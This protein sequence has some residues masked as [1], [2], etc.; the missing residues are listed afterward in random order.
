MIAAGQRFGRLVVLSVR[1]GKH[2]VARCRCD[3]GTDKDVRA[4]VLIAGQAKSC[5]CFRSERITRMSTKHGRC[6]TPEW[7]VWRGLRQRCQDPNCAGYPDYGG[8]GITVCARWDG[9]GGFERFLADMGPRPSPDHSID[10]IEN[11]G[12]YSPENCRWATRSAQAKNRRERARL[13]D[14]TFAPRASETH[15]VAV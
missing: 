9:D 8:R 7:R 15:H 3:C 14:G 4:S 12:P 11:D 5:G 2:T 10:R 13:A 1:G 6:Y